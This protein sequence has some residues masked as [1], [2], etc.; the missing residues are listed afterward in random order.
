MASLWCLAVHTPGCTESLWAQ[1]NTPSYPPAHPSWRRCHPISRVTL[2]SYKWWRDKV[3]QL[4]E[5]LCSACAPKNLCTSTTQQHSYRSFWTTCWP[6]TSAWSYA[7]SPSFSLRSHW[8]G[9]QSWTPSTLPSRYRHQRQKNIFLEGDLAASSWHW[10]SSYGDRTIPW[11]KRRLACASTMSYNISEYDIFLPP[12]LPK[13][14]IA[15]RCN[16]D[17]VSP[18]SG[19]KNSLVMGGHSPSLT[20]LY[21]SSMSRL[22]M[23]PTQCESKNVVHISQ[24]TREQ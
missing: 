21:F 6:S 22:T 11:Y 13:R 17:F 3:K 14:C 16:S 15:Q 5:M 2:S 20:T 4:H 7:H 9:I 1:K 18:W 23:S 10:S 24:V 19:L 8:C 12:M